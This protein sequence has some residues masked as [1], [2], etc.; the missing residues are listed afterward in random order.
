VLLGSLPFSG[1]AGI[2]L[3]VLL[4][5][6]DV[7][8]K[9]F[10]LQLSLACLRYIVNIGGC[11]LPGIVL[12]LDDPRGEEYDQLLAV[13]FVC[14]ATKEISEKRYLA[15]VRNARSCRRYVLPD[16]PSDEDRLAVLNHKVRCRLRLF[17][18][19]VGLAVEK[20]DSVV[21]RDFLGKVESDKSA[22][23]DAGL[24]LEDDTD[25]LVLDGP[26]SVGGGG[27]YRFRCHDGD[28]LTHL[29]P[30][31]LVIRHQYTRH[32]K[33]LRLRLR[34]KRIDDRLEVTPDGPRK[35]ECPTPCRARRCRA[36]H[37]ESNGPVHCPQH[38]VHTARRELKG[39]GNAELQ[40][41][42]QGDLRDH[43][44]DNDLP[45]DNI[46]APDGLLDDLIIFGQAEDNEGVEVLLGD[47]LRYGRNKAL[48]CLRTRH[49]QSAFR[50]AARG[51]GAGCACRLP[52]G[53]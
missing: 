46:D 5:P 49:D 53:R 4:L 33:K 12:V 2:I 17:H 52:R 14:S 20:G 47:N 10:L 6:G 15:E 44:F 32:G 3:P 43:P 42:L 27:R 18:N 23:I 39:P 11:G 1:L 21:G 45:R 28:L 19:D 50:P 22:F 34:R 24:Y 9:L 25:V 37:I 41:I 13:I 26:L 30:S 51:R 7:A 29:D 31:L 35:G 40:I 36:G 38:A 8:D 16:K 48:S